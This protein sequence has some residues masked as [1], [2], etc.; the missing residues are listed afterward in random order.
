VPPLPWSPQ[1]LWSL[2]SLSRE[3][4]QNLHIYLQLFTRISPRDPSPLQEGTSTQHRFFSLL[5]ALFEAS[6]PQAKHGCN[7]PM[8]EKYLMLWT[9]LVGAS[10]LGHSS[11]QDDCPNPFAKQKRPQVLPTKKPPEGQWL[12]LSCSL[13]S[14]MAGILPGKQFLS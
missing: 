10:S 12:F 7:S 3:C 8:Q 2:L 6:L 1:L 9:Q 5:H 14:Q 11:F 13:H 4:A